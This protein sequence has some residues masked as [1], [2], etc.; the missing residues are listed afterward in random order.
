MIK[1]KGIAEIRK[2]ISPVLVP[3]KNINLCEDGIYEL[4]FKLDAEESAFIDLEL[5]VEVELRIKNLPEGI[6]AVKIIA[7]E[8]SDIE[9]IE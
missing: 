8:N 9:L 7:S 4:D 5:E 3:G 6:K 1:A 2:L